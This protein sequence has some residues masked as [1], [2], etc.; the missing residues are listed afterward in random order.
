MKI[1]EKIALIKSVAKKE[2]SVSTAM[3]SFA[4]NSSDDVLLSLN[5]ESPIVKAH[6][7]NGSKVLIGVNHLSLLL[8]KLYREE[9]KFPVALKK[10]MLHERVVFEKNDAVELKAIHANGELKVEAYYNENGHPVKIASATADKNQQLSEPGEMK[11]DDPLNTLTYS[12]KEV[13]EIF[14]KNGVKY[15]DPLITIKEINISETAARST[16]VNKLTLDINN[17][18]QVNPAFLDASI[19]S[20]FFCAFLKSNNKNVFIPLFINQVIC[21]EGLGERCY[22]QSTLK[23]ANDEITIFDISIYNEEKREVLRLVGVN[24]KRI[25]TPDESRLTDEK[26]DQTLL[27]EEAVRELTDNTGKVTDE[28]IALCRNYLIEK[29]SNLQGNPAASTNKLL[30]TN[31]MDLGIESQTLIEMTEEIEKNFVIELYPT[32]FFEYQNVKELSTYLTE[33]HDKELRQYFRLNK[34]ELKTRKQAVSNSI[35]EEVSV[36]FKI[37]QDA[38]EKSN[39]SKVSISVNSNEVAIIGMAGRFSKSDTLE[40]FWHN[41]K[42]GSDLM[43]EIPESRWS[44]KNHYDPDKKLK[45]KSYC[46]WGSF[47]NHVDKFDPLFFN[48]SPRE[49]KM[50]D[51]QMRHLLENLYHTAEDAGIMSKLR[52]SN[53][54]M[55]VG[56][57]FHD[58]QTESLLHNKE[59]D[60]FDGI[61]NALTMLANRPS[62]YFDL[63]GPSLTVDTACSSSLVALDLACK[64]L[65][66]NTC[67]M[68]FV[69]GVNLLLSP[70]HY[71]YFSSIGALSSTGRCHSFDERADGYVPG[72]GIAS[73]LLKPLHKA[74]E[75]GDQIHAVIKGSAVKHGGYTNSITAPSARTEA[76]VIEEAWKNSGIQ[77]SRL[78]YI[79]AHGTGT[80]LGDPI[81]VEA[82]KMA[83]NKHTK[84]QNFCKLGSVKSNIGHTEGAAGISGLI[85]TVLCMKNKEIPAMPQFQQLNPY[86]K[87]QNSPF[88][89]NEKNTSWNSDQP[90]LAGISSFG[91]GGTYAHV[92]IEES[93]KNNNREKQNDELETIVLSAKCKESLRMVAYELG[94]FIS[95]NNKKDWCSLKNIAYSLMI[96]REVFSERLAMLVTSLTDLENALYNYC[97]DVQD[98]CLFFNTVGEESERV[99]ILSADLLVKNPNVFATKWTQGAAM[100]VDEIIGS[101]RT[102]SVKISLP[103]YSFLKESYWYDLPDRSNRKAGMDAQHELAFA[104]SKAEAK[105]IF[106]KLTRQ[107]AVIREHVVQNKYIMPGVGVMEL[108]LE[109]V[110]TASPQLKG[111]LSFV[112]F[113]LLSPLEI[114]D[115][116]P[117]ETVAVIQ[118]ADNNKIRVELKN[119]VNEH[120]FAYG[121]LTGDL[122]IEHKK[123]DLELVKNRCAKK[124]TGFEIYQRFK[125]I[126]INYGESFK[127]IDHLYANEKEVLAIIKLP[128]TSD[129]QHKGYIWNPFLM[130]AIIQCSIGLQKEEYKEN[131]M[132]PYKFENSIVSESIPSNCL[133]H[134]TLLD[135][136]VA[137]KSCSL[138]IDIF[139]TSYDLIGSI[140]K[141]TLKEINKQAVQSQLPEQ[142][143]QLPGYSYAWTP[144]SISAYHMQE[145]KES[146]AQNK[147]TLWIYTNPESLSVIKHLQKEE[148]APVL[149]VLLGKENTYSGNEYEI[150]PG[151]AEFS[152][153]LDLNEGITDVCWL[154]ELAENPLNGQTLKSIQRYSI[155]SLFHF[156]KAFDYKNKKDQPLSIKL[157]TLNANVVIAGEQSFPD[158]TALKGFA[159]VLPKEYNWLKIGLLDVDKY[160]WKRRN[161]F[162]LEAWNTLPLKKLCNEFAVRNNNIYCNKYI[163]LR[164]PVV[165]AKLDFIVPNGNYLVVGGMGGLGTQFCKWLTSEANVN[166]FII[167]QSSLN[168]ERQ[169]LLETYNLSGSKAHYWQL[170]ITQENT[171][172]NA[173]VAANL[174]EIHGVVMS[175]IRLHDLS[176]NELT[177]E[178]F[179]IAYAPKVFG[180]WALY[181]AVKNLDVKNVLLF[182]S[183]NAD[184][185]NKSQSNYAAA[186]A[187]E[188]GFADYWSATSNTNVQLINWGFWEQTGIVANASNKN[189][190]NALGIGG[191]KNDEGIQFLQTVLALNKT[192]VCVAKLSE[193]VKNI[194]Q[195]ADQQHGFDF[196]QA[197]AINAWKFSETDF[198]FDKYLQNKKLFQEYLIL[199]LQKQLK[200]AWAGQVVDIPDFNIKNKVKP[201]YESIILAAFNLLQEHEFF[202]KINENRYVVEQQDKDNLSARSE[203]LKQELLFNSA[204]YKS[205]IELLDTCLDNFLKVISGEVN[206]AT[207]LFPNGSP[208]LV[209]NIYKGNS[210]MD[211]YNN[212]VASFVKESLCFKIEKGNSEKNKFKILE[213]GAGTGSTSQFVLENLKGFENKV[214]YFYTDISQS[215]L[216]AASR[217]FKDYPFV[218]YK[219]LD[220]ENPG[221]SFLPL[222]EFDFVIASNVLHAT[223]SI[224]VTLQNVHSFLNN[225]GCLI[226]NEMIENNP[227]NTFT[228]GLT[229]EWWKF[230]DT[231]SRL[232]LSPALSKELWSKA[233][234]NNGFEQ[235]EFFGLNKYLKEEPLQVIIAQK[236][237]VYVYQITNDLKNTEQ[238]I[239]VVQKNSSMI[240]INDNVI[241]YLR[242]IFS[243]VLQ[244]SED[245]ISPAKTYDE[246]GVDSISGQ[247][248]IDRLKKDIPVLNPV[249]LF[250]CSNIEQLAAFVI[251]EYPSHI[252]QFEPVKNADQL[253]VNSTVASFSENLKEKT[254]VFKECKSVSLAVLEKNAKPE[255]DDPNDEIAIIGFAGKYPQAE[256][257]EEFWKNLAAGKNCIEEVPKDRWDVESHYNPDPKNESTAYSKWGGFIKDVDKFDAPFFKM[258][259]AEAELAD[260]QIRLFL[261]NS[262]SLLENAGYTPESLGRNVG[263]FIGAMSSQYQLI[264]AEEMMKGNMLFPHCGYWAIANRVS[265]FFNFTGPSM[266]ID[267]ACSSSLSALHLACRSIQNNE[268]NVAIVGGINLI[269]HPSRYIQYCQFNMLSRDEKCKV[270]DNS[271]DGFVDGEGVGSV[272]LKRKKDAIADGDFIYGVIK[273]TAV[274]AGGKSG[275]FTVP[276]VERQAELIVKNLE[277]SGIHPEQIS[278]IEAHGTGTS[279]G[280]PIEIRALSKAFGKFSGKKNFCA[281]GSVKSNIGH[282]EAAAGIASLSKV[283]LQLNKCYLVPSINFQKENSKINFKDTPFYVQQ[284]L[285]PWNVTKDATGKV[286]P[287]TAAISSFGAGGSNSH[288]IVQGYEN[289]DNSRKTAV[290]KVILLSSDKLDL[291]IKARLLKDFLEVNNNSFIPEQKNIAYTLQ[292]GR[293]HM[294][295]RVAFLADDVPHLL[296]L[297]KLYTEDEN[298]S[299]YIYSN[300]TVADPAPNK[301]A[302]KLKDLIE[303]NN[304]SELCEEWINGREINWIDLYDSIKPLKIQL[305]GHLFRKNRYWLKQTDSDMLLTKKI[306]GADL[307][308]ENQS[309]LEKIKFIKQFTGKEFLFEHHI[310][311]NNKILPGVAYMEIMRQVM[312]SL[313]PK[314]P[315]ESISGFVF[316]SPLI[317]KGAVSEISINI[318]PQKKH[319]DA[320]INTE[321]NQENQL[322]AMGKL[323]LRSQLNDRVVPHE[324]NLDAIKLRCSRVI[325][326][327]DVYSTYASSG[328]R[329]GES[330]RGIQQV[331]CGETE[332]LSFIKIPDHLLNSSYLFHP[333]VLDS[334]L[335][336]IIGIDL[337]IKTEKM[338]LPFSFKHFNS[339]RP[340]T[341]KCYVYVRSLSDKYQNNDEIF[342]FDVDIMDPFGKILARISEFSVRTFDPQLIQAPE[343]LQKKQEHTSNFYLPIW[344]N[345][346]SFS[347]TEGV[348]LNIQKSLLFSIDKS[349]LELIEDRDDFIMVTPGSTYEWKSKQEVTLSPDN[350]SH[351]VRL[352]SDLEELNIDIN[353]LLHLWNLHTGA[354]ELKDSEDLLNYS[355]RSAFFISKAILKTKKWKKVPIYYC[356]KWSA[357][358]A[359]SDSVNAFSK[360]YRKENPQGEFIVVEF[361]KGYPLL[362]V[363]TVLQY[364]KQQQRKVDVKYELG[365][366]KTL[367][368]KQ[369]SE[370]IQNIKLLKEND[371]IIIVGG[372]T[373]IGKIVAEHLVKK[374]KV[375]VFSIGR[376]ATPE[377]NSSQ[378]KLANSENYRIR[379]FSCDITN[380]QNLDTCLEEIR[381]YGPISGV[382]HAGGIVA[383]QFLIQ[384]TID[385]FENVIKPKVKGTIY[386]DELT[387][388]DELKFFVVFSSMSAVTGNIGQADYAAANCF[389]DAYMRQRNLQV[390]SGQ[391]YGKSISINW[392]YWEEGGMQIDEEYI[393]MMEKQGLKA[394]EKQSGLALLETAISKSFEQ[395]LVAVGDHD[396]IKNILND[397][398]TLVDKASKVKQDVILQITGPAYNI[399]DIIKVVVSCLSE[400]LKINADELD[401]DLDLEEM[402]MDSILMMK[403]LGRIE[404]VFDIVIDPNLLVENSTIRKISEFLLQNYLCDKRK[405]SM[406]IIPEK[407]KQDSLVRSLST[408]VTHALAKE[409]QIEVFSNQPVAIIGVACKFP[410]A[411]NT[412]EFWE[413]LSNGT[414]MITEVPT[415]RWSVQSTKFKKEDSIKPMYGAFIKNYDHFDAAYFKISDAEA[416]VMDPQQRIL[417]ELSQEL[418]DYAGYEKEELDGSKTNVYIGGTASNYIGIHEHLLTSELSRYSIVNNIQNMM[419]ARI[420]DY[421]NFKGYSGTL[422]TACSSSLVAIH[423]AV[424]AIRSG[425]CDYAIAGG[426]SLLLDQHA[427]DGFNSADILAKDGKVKVF[428]ENADG[429]VLGEGGGLVML[430]S[431]KKA[432]ADGDQI[433]GVIK[434]TAV[435]ND[436]RTMGVT[437]PSR[438]AQK[439]VI[440]AAIK[441]AKVDVG[442][443]SY[444]EAHG[445]GTL[446]GDPIE[447]QAATQVYKEF[448][449]DLQYCATGSVKSNVGH[450]LTAAGIC[451]FIKVIL[452][453]QKGKIP[454]TLNCNK[455]HPRFKFEQSPFFPATV[456]Q[457]WPSIAGER[458]AAISSF[459]FGGTNC[460]MILQDHI[461][462]DCKRKKKVS[463]A[464][465]RKIYCLGKKIRSV[466][467]NQILNIIN[468]FKKG[469][470]TIQETEQLIEH[471]DTNYLDTNYSN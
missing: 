432:I 47:V 195:V 140:E 335:Q 345:D 203:A 257:M 191:I 374:Y 174:T 366:R 411:D 175:V 65:Q 465:N 271:A 143:L 419:A 9:K 310:V 19:V 454:P 330:F 127:G 179:N 427:H 185:A 399:G 269:I 97:N 376:R 115:E 88:T 460:H 84:E 137:S 94:S 313:Y 193:N 250:E 83:F 400:V 312:F 169:K 449:S 326:S 23:K 398:V 363:L 378:V 426:I 276:D 292:T 281:I 60:P 10:F 213:I 346:H 407:I 159:K 184:L 44:I 293:I 463:R 280:D 266:A 214:E 101:R 229:K 190:L 387:Q 308:D 103:G 15:S 367:G 133:V 295:H 274:N 45:D 6:L 328:L 92:V 146:T 371:N 80:K 382:L 441:D 431:Y 168:G 238:K 188:N 77:P 105:E 106:V 68:A 234:L 11:W 63:K 182:S 259:P 13:Y 30:N 152:S 265:Y 353:Q 410:G 53:T 413:K 368:F 351:Y 435:N 336:T 325:K 408:E 319:F 39:D 424:S 70:W 5:C 120:L 42:N 386:L 339:Y 251:K 471:L 359:Y 59:I 429:F 303:S 206:P 422:D 85:K 196:N 453:L 311:A 142:P 209:T 440:K 417:L 245:R 294:K 223:T 138:R 356:F 183:I 25:R 288:L 290:H 243:E 32:I 221:N 58:Y 163:A 155:F 171:L 64:A 178:Q 176:V 379:H 12:G 141:L 415:T 113:T 324:C 166:L 187:F 99:E 240:T 416:L 314:D 360:S 299:S 338:F 199:S 323:L 430:K 173:L 41:L 260:P 194:L 131:L 144:V 458:F 228:F 27:H 109:S 322:H 210:L 436:G 119:K 369:H 158:L 317:N 452:S 450:L 244:I 167:G 98:K 298:E 162:I 55:Y 333:S 334:A 172:K 145:T 418:I 464:F 302:P 364:E 75:D 390:Y 116:L 28:I 124:L 128:I 404:T 455:P 117:L 201:Y 247:E 67:E 321:A 375:N 384:K 391:G 236:D 202:R 95:R 102:N 125:N 61:G 189:R 248:L 352:F 291:K 160:E 401:A 425:N 230:T 29:I 21:F 153:F 76:M 329:Y 100:D 20:A 51:P 72:E 286:L 73:V 24:C 412:E 358:S 350:P 1:E 181:N 14:G 81:E 46:K 211:F 16:Q 406:E 439:E 470:L 107:H 132:L 428:D 361:D 462:D 121:S 433:L 357:N 438:D 349:Y 434:G 442:K 437:T 421:Y 89:I 165:K 104:P 383:D 222:A 389:M 466:E 289:R 148:N 267:T 301:P 36:E 54:G 423:Q 177:E 347:L 108:I 200:T 87:I 392:P 255:P 468:Q 149:Y 420:S 306:P 354:F 342:S 284:Q 461:S 147:K 233:L 457:D 74:L 82:L 459:G 447:I 17:G 365:K 272:L 305:P 135:F 43:E 31:F 180:N 444:L 242:K 170:D 217:K 285:E 446:L 130:D 3:Q 57:C 304:L 278:Y 34:P 396:K 467:E 215:F 7:V 219:L 263:V 161:P 405:E 52:G 136:N 122:Y 388:K 362:D 112:S 164:Q 86:V 403:T 373:G 270:F 287:R 218:E 380:K 262:W 192:K 264:G 283:L 69:S 331:Y 186:C 197:H 225:S 277:A 111:K 8:E 37:N 48:I 241:G 252:S 38:K 414:S 469:L 402:G 343:E 337:K 110:Y 126:G 231:E 157:I 381:S 253:S 309:S 226:L 377:K 307:W 397:R 4:G 50:M 2:I 282:L 156:I 22:S 393:R 273:G 79:E 246:Y 35:N 254:V 207:V 93:I 327:Q 216:N 320:E 316:A 258:S 205:Y 297:L 344:E 91:F 235:V 395:V 134:L 443:I 151:M 300:D 332:A 62:F 129:T 150:Y 212:S 409:D 96:G 71:K 33:N 451:G 372:Q 232:P 355:V 394:L 40:Q 296:S 66:N 237:P 275:G 370:S 118:H 261:E 268:C 456:L 239:T 220:I 18:L 208:E 348:P 385:Q 318:V 90:L 224:S 139:S 315:V 256:S 249:V 279:L 123:L 78:S 154:A 56:V 445:T 49:A 26:R 341:E 340:L 204:A 227:F 198:P 114:N 448:G